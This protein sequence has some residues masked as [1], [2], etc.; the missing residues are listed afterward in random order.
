MFFHQKLFLG[1]RKNPIQIFSIPPL[2]LFCKK[3]S[4]QSV[5]PERAA[6]SQSRAPSQ[7]ALPPAVFLPK[8]PEP[9][10]HESIYSGGWKYARTPYPPFFHTKINGTPKAK[11]AL[12]AL[13]D[14]H[15][16]AFGLLDKSGK[17]RLICNG[18]FRKH[19]AVQRNASFLE[20]VHEGGIVDIIHPACCGNSRDPQTA[21]ILSCAVCGRY[22][23]NCRTSSRPV[24]PF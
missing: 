13:S 1:C 24:W 4:G 5:T 22:R 9:P 7:K 10:P 14:F 12:G 20:A 23:H 21:E 15:K 18:N 11:S 16:A 6:S 8:Q 17:R 19:F 2:R 3:N